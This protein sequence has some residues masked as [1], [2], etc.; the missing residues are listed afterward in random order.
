M[1]WLLALGISDRMVSVFTAA[2]LA[3][4]AAAAGDAEAAGRLWGA[5]ESEEATGPIGQ[6]PGYRAEYERRRAAARPAGREFEQAR[7]RRS[8]ALALDD[9]SAGRASEA[10]T[11]P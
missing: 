4:T 6:W 5:I 7:A 8:P 9:S 11:E 10:Q 1:H 2:E 3:S